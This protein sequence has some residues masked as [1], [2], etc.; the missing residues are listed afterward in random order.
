MNMQWK[1]L[2][3]LTLA[4]LLLLTLFAIPGA[5]LVTEE[6][7]IV[8]SAEEEAERYKSVEALVEKIRS[9]RTQQ[10]ELEGRIAAC[11]E[12]VSS[13]VQEKT[14]LDGLLT[15]CFQELNCYDQLLY[16]YDELL[17]SHQ[18][19]YVQL[20]EDIST[21]HARLTVRLRQSHEEGVPGLLELLATSTDLF[22]L[23]LSFERLNELQ[24][25]DEQLMSKLE[26][27]HSDR[28]DLR[29]EI[30]QI[31]DERHQIAIK[32]VERTRLF[33]GKLQESGNFLLNLQG[34]VHRFSYFIQQS[35]A[36]VQR[37]EQA[38]MQAVDA[39][40]AEL[41]EQIFEELESKRIQKEAQMTVQMTQLMERGILQQGAQYFLSGSQYILPFYL[42]GDRV[43]A[44]TSAM[45]YCT[46]QIDGKVIGDYHGGVDLASSYGVP[47]VA[48]ASGVVVATGFEQGY[49][50]Y[51]VIWH[52][53]DGSQTRYA[54]L[55]EVTV[56]TGDYL[57]QGEALGTVGSSGYSKGMGCH[58]ELWIDGKR[59]NPVSV[60]TFPAV[61]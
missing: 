38:I 8:L 26:T 16:I 42:T 36:G 58:F 61:E 19:K 11:H 55:A 41:D 31:K 23:I 48:S 7:E 51:V 9:L 57:I 24:T 27:M 10:T 39:Y 6:S 52:D 30:D 34:D 12:D 45:G 50:N 4:P 33:N 59:V 21:Y 43:P 18:N 35:Q 25:Y 20:E 49:G 53:S 56:T 13:V 5:A 37:A 15:L 17:F 22:S 46:Y 1:R 54:H 44:I 29:S 28:I 60:L 14:L 32:Q 2:I 40:I 3:S 47:V